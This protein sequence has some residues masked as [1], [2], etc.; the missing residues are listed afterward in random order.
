M[1][2]VGT[3]KGTR[4]LLA[5]LALAL[6]AGAPIEYRFGSGTGYQPPG[7]IRRFGC[8]LFSWISGRS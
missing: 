4:L 2:T 7:D 6:A 5:S 3:K 1:K 8:P